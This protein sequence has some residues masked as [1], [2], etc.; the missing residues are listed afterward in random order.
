LRR[1]GPGNGYT[2]EKRAF[3]RAQPKPLRGGREE[4][5]RSS[6]PSATESGRRERLLPL[7]RETKGDPSHARGNSE[8]RTVFPDRGRK[9]RMRKHDKIS[10]DRKSHRQLLTGRAYLGT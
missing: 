8:G 9:K 6:S 5:R 2:G 4:S 7:V 3:H 1:K 10:E